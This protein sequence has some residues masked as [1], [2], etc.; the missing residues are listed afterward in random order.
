M[1]KQLRRSEVTATPP[2][3]LFALNI[4]V[5]LPDGRAL[6]TTF[7]EWIEVAT[8]I[9]PQIATPTTLESVHEC[10]Y[11]LADDVIEKRRL[12]P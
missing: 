2:V 8:G 1:G 9:E 5:Y 12:R 10:R 11:P 6:P 7:N 3:R 4:M